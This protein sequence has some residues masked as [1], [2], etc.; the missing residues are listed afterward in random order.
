MH[1]HRVGHEPSCNPLRRLISPFISSVSL[2][3]TDPPAGSCSDHGRARVHSSPGPVRVSSRPP[4][5]PPGGPRWAPRRGA[6]ALSARGAAG[7]EE[8]GGEE[9]EGRAGAGSGGGGG[10]GGS[11]GGGPGMT[12]LRRSVLAWTRPARR[13]YCL[14]LL[15]VCAAWLCALLY[16]SCFAERMVARGTRLKRVF[17]PNERPV[18]GVLAQQTHGNLARHG[19]TYI[20]ASYIKYLEAAGARVAPIRVNLTNAEYEKVFYSINGLLLPGGGADLQTSGYAHAAR[21]LYKLAIKANDRGDYF[22]VW[23][24]CLGFE[25]LTVLTS[26]INVLT[27]TK[28]TRYVALPLKFTP[29]F[30]ES[31]MFRNIMPEVVRA[32]AEE[33]I[34]ANV[35]YKS[36]SVKNFTANEKLRNFYWVLS[37]NVDEKG[38]QFISTMEAYEYPFYGVQ[39][40][41][42]K[43][44]FEWKRGKSFPHSRS[45]V[46]VAFHLA[47]F[48]V[49][50]AR[51][52]LH[53]FANEAE[54]NAALIYHHAAV[55]TSEESSFEQAY[56]FS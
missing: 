13:M 10:G 28:S 47:D 32:M 35:H 55:Y 29:G 25:Q 31:R 5:R 44:Q 7:Q 37:T 3:P 52:N 41:P 36:L 8:G 9:E 12:S 15:A 40:H 51:K 30:E 50:E 22:P 38:L 54:E 48:F 27:D 1:G 21:I 42:E 49:T 17:A 26:G 11:G 46:H 39:W 24:T 14:L 19:S 20:A 53:A 4:L 6:T 18:V 23:G 45:A 2:F 16:K 56:F 33:P 43:N 34:S